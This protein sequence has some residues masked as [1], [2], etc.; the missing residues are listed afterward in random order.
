M[1]LNGQQ[2]D[3]EDAIYGPVVIR[4]GKKLHGFYASPVWSYDLFHK[5]CPEPE[6][7]VSAYG[8]DGKKKHDVK[9]PIYL[10]ALSRYGRQLWGFMVLTSLI[11]AKLDLSEHGVSID[12]PNT[13]DKVEEALRHDEEKNP[14]G[15]SHYEFKQVMDLVDEANLLDPTKLESNLQSFL[16]E[17]VRQEEPGKNSLGSDQENS[18]FGELANGGE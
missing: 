9:N 14:Q 18:S 13:W 2:F 16:A 17:E 5:L 4:R 8:Q 3:N 11:P 12:D 15:L 7:P 6:P 1:K 10:E